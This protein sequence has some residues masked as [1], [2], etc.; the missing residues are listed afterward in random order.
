MTKNLYN[1]IKNTCFLSYLLFSI[2]IF[3]YRVETFQGVAQ[4]GGRERFVGAVE[5]HVV[6]AGQ[7]RFDGLRPAAGDEN[8][9]FHHDQAAFPMTRAT[10]S[11]MTAGF[12]AT[13]TPTAERISTFSEALSPK[14]EM[15]APA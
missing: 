7:L 6:V 13:V 14:A 1:Q 15:I 3:Y 8:G 11:P 9:G 4:V 5:G 12:S 10:V 2:Q